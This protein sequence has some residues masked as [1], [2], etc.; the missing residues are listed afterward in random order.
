MDEMVTGDLESQNSNNGGSNGSSLI[1]T[2]ILH[3]MVRD[4]A[5]SAS[6]KAQNR[7][8]KQAA[9]LKRDADTE[10]RNKFRCMQA[11]KRAREV[12]ST[13]VQLTK[14]S[15]PPIIHDKHRPVLNAG[16]F[17]DVSPNLTPGHCSYGGHAW[18]VDC[19]L[20]D[21]GR[22]LVSV[23][24]AL[25]GNTEKHIELTRITPIE[26]PQHARARP[27]KRTTIAT[28]PPPTEELMTTRKEYIDKPIEFLLQSA[29]SAN[30]GLRWRRKQLGLA[31]TDVKDGRF[32]Q[33]LLSDYLSLKAYL[34]V[35]K[36]QTQTDAP[37]QHRKRGND[38]QWTSRVQRNNPHTM[39]YLCSVAWDV[40]INLP[41]TLQRRSYGIMTKATPKPTT[42]VKKMKGLSVI[43]DRAY[44]KATY[45]ATYLFTLDY[46]KRTKDTYHDRLPTKDQV[47]EW[48]ARAARAWRYSTKAQREVWDM[49]AREHENQQPLIAERVIQSLQTNASKS[50]GAVSLDIGEWCS[51]STIQVWLASFKSYSI[52]VERVLPLLSIVQR[53][54][55]VTFS[56]LLRSN[57]NLPKAKY[58]WIHYDEKWFYGFV[59]RSNAKKCPELGLEKEMHAIYHRNHISK[60]MAVAFTAYTVDDHVENGGDGLK[61]GFFR[62][63]SA[64]VAAKR[65]R[66]SRRDEFGRLRYDGE[67][68]REKGDIYLVDST[69]TGS[70][71][72]TCRSPKYPLLP[73]F[74]DT[75][76]PKVEALVGVGGHYAGYIPIIQGDNAGP[77]Q[78]GDFDASCKA[79]CHTRG[80][81][82]IPQAPQMPY[83]NNLDLVVFPC[84]SKRHT[85]LLR[86]HGNSVIPNDQIWKAAQEVWNDLESYV[87]AR[88][89]VLAYRIAAKVIEGEGGNDF[90]NNADFHCEV[91]KDFANT[92]T[93][94]KRASVVN[95]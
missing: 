84:M 19:C 13:L 58:L 4:L 48:K 49:K 14:A 54:K 31:E 45:T 83:A 35:T 34:L 52:Y 10:F 29:Y 23:R 30:K 51:A 94:I 6:N 28:I 65:V 39:A 18:V 57:W 78:E 95:I 93:G 90:L 47:G 60:V 64:R 24:Y 56:K 25:E 33:C 44:A 7:V 17:V 26:I 81:H 72:G 75:V 69:V 11:E 8:L 22:T 61:L 15:T 68:L 46:V 40:S 77:H 79:Y 85:Q 71:A 63:Q 82:W 38:G 27:P 67:V 92:A 53:E 43:D 74:L 80:W 50:Y 87:I 41:R 2:T 91:R 89:F 66:K 16:S 12:E 76:F 1:A 70:D 55:H 59:T 21:N 88:G 86:Q 5:F 20:D 3:P 9:A 62:V 42:G 32:R 37:N 73:L 36:R